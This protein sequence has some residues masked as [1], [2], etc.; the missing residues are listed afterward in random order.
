MPAPVDMASMMQRFACK[1]FS[2]EEQ[3]LFDELQ[4]LEDLAPTILSEHVT[5][6]APLVESRRMLESHSGLAAG[7]AKLRTSFATGGKDLAVGQPGNIWAQAISNTFP[8]LVT[9]QDSEVLSHLSDVRSRTAADGKSFVLEFE[10]DKS[11]PHLN[12]PHVLQSTFSIEHKPGERRPDIQPV[13]ATGIEWKKG[14]NPTVELVP[15]G[16]RSRGANERQ[17]Q[18]VPIM[19]FFHF[20]SPVPPASADEN[21]PANTIDRGE[22][23]RF[24][25]S[26]VAV[27]PVPYASMERRC[28]GVEDEDEDDEEDEEFDEEDDEEDEDSDSSDDGHGGKPKPA[29]PPGDCKQQ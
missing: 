6:A 13:T 29:A 2:A 8:G 15:I 10:F 22:I 21:D 20:F 3:S 1:G 23:A 4:R 14:K 18:S 26:S 5:L 12:A 28:P 25:R 7:R 9:D 27:N 17:E 16:K 11:S 19:S 24:L